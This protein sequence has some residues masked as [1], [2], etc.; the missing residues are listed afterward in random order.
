M[1]KDELRGAVIVHENLV[2]TPYK[3]SH[4]L[5]IPNSGFMLGIPEYMV[6]FNLH[7]IFVLHATIA[8]L[9][10]LLSIIKLL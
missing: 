7:A 4:T 3:H 8:L 6:E 1:G 5:V 10:G 2:R 9:K